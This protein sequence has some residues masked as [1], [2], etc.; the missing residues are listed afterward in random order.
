MKAA[1]Q[2]DQDASDQA[3]GASSLPA[4]SRPRFALDP[5]VGRWLA[6]LLAVGISAA[7]LV[8]RKQL[9]GLGAYGYPGLFLINL[10]A[11]ATLF[12][13]VPGLALAFAAGGSFSPVLV[14]L[15]TGSGA[16]LGELTG[17]LAGYG[18]RGVIENQARYRQI[19]GWMKRFGL[20]VIFVLSLIPNPI[21]DM[22]GIAAGAMRM[23]W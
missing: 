9:V 11:S 19:E 4:S 8:F 2:I 20:V 5:R 15:A 18:G 22:A 23:Y 1:A 7:I 14:G 10:F 16:A 6:L 12:L 17:Y 13:P 3:G 21:F